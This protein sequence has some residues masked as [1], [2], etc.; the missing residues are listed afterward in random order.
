[1]VGLSQLQLARA[2]SVGL[3]S[4]QMYEQRQKNINKAAA[5]T[6]T[7]FARALSCAID[8]LLEY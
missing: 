3:R 7:N 4:I 1:M 8:D 6:L 5:M 2:S